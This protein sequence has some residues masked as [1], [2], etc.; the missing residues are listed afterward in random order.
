MNKKLI[1]TISLL[2]ILL[3]GNYVIKGYPKQWFKDYNLFTEILLTGGIVGIAVIILSLINWS[4]Y[5]ILKKDFLIH[6]H[7][8]LILLYGYIDT[9]HIW[10]VQPG[11]IDF[12]SH[13]TWTTATRVLVILTINLILFMINKTKKEKDI[14]NGSI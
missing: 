5:F 2:P 10:S 7:S 12:R 1:P 8:I 3:L 11:K 6:I 13:L 9:L 14:T 4:I